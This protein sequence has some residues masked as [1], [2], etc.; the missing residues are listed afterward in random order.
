MTYGCEP[1]SIAS[2]ATRGFWKVA[3][4][5][6]LDALQYFRVFPADDG[7]LSPSGTS[8]AEAHHR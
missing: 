4:Y 6:Y 2:G 3:V 8:R 7:R 5:Y 1:G